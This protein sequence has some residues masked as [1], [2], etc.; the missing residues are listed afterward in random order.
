MTA[1]LGRRGISDHSAVRVTGRVRRSGSTASRRGG[2]ASGPTGAVSPEG[3]EIT[4]WLTTEQVSD[5]RQINFGSAPRVRPHACG[6]R[7]A[8]ACDLVGPTQGNPIIGYGGN[9]AEK[10]AALTSYRKREFLNRETNG[11]SINSRLLVMNGRRA[12]DVQCTAAVAGLPGRRERPAQRLL[13]PNT[14]R[15]NTSL[16]TGNGSVS[17][18]RT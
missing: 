13:S 7:S 15:D 12:I 9:G 18:R 1:H 4:R 5:T 6:S 16:P 8:N 2:L 11:R 10:G 17:H 3:H 14:Q